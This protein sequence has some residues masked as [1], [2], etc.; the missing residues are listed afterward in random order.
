MDAELPLGWAFATADELSD[1]VPNALAIGP[2]GSNLKVQDYRTSGVPLVF[3]REIRRE[4]F[5]GADTKYISNEKA[6]ELAAHVVRPGELLITKMGDPPGDTA[7][8]PLDRPGAVI[9]SDCIKLSP[10]LKVTSSDFLALLLRSPGV[11]SL[12]VEQTKGVAQQ[13]LSLKRFREIQFPLPPLNE[14]RRIVAKLESLLACSRRAKE[15]LDAIPALLERFR[16]SVLSAAFRG[17]LTQDWREANPDVEP[18][19]KLLERIRSERRR[20]WEEAEL[21]RMQSKGKLPKDEKWKAEYKEPECNDE[22]GAFGPVSGLGWVVAPVDGLCDPNRGVPYGIVQTGDE[23]ADGVPTVRCGDLKD[24]SIDL[25]LLKRVAPSI[26]QQYTRT[27]LSGGEVLLAIR[28]TVGGV[29]V[30]SEKMRGMNISREVAMLPVLPGVEPRFVMYLLASPAATALLAGRTK[31]VAQQGVNLSDLRSLPVPL[32]SLAE[33]VQIVRRVDAAM[34]RARAVAR[35]CAEAVSRTPSLEAAILAK[36]CRGELV[37]QDPTDEPASA[38][39]ERI[40]AENNQPAD[41]DPTA[42]SK[43]RRENKVA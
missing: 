41:S 34:S 9:T 12:L 11:R 37:P 32:P 7:V 5:G 21:K 16:Q 1:T 40:R 22:A 33:Q 17:D 15:S 4:R 23:T 39:L 20:R 6:A 24:F 38:L 26:E 8:Y 29:A 18:A 35:V 14:Q 25:A 3:V 36:A 42:R 10:N 28:G 2:F 13:K 43:R 30:A 31:G 27:R 19:S